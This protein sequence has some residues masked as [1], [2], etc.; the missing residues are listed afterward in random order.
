MLELLT[1]LVLQS[2][3]RRRADKGGGVLPL[4]EKKKKKTI[5]YLR[6][7]NKERW[8]SLSDWS[9]CAPGLATPDWGDGRLNNGKVGSTKNTTGEHNG[10]SCV[11]PNLYAKTLEIEIKCI[12]RSKVRFCLANW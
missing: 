12:K 11:E 4:E 10:T 6:T 5:I 1:T 2:H 8:F 9:G 3:E 7:T